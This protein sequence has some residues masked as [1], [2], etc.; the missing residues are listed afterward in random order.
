VKR[1]KKTLPHYK[2]RKIK[3]REDCVRERRM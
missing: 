1:E 3:E 2:L